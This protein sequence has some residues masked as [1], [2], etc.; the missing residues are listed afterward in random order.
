MHISVQVFV[1]AVVFHGLDDT[2][3]GAHCATSG[4]GKKTVFGRER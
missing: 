1:L 2:L 3:L 4:N